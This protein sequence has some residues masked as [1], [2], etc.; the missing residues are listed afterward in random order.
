VGGVISPLLA[1]IYLNP[2][3]H[4]M[5]QQGFEMVRYAD[6]FVILCQTPEEAEHALRLVKEWTGSAGLALHP[7]KTSI[8]NVNE[9]GFEFLGYRFYKDRRWPRKKSLETFK[10]ALRV[11]TKRTNGCSLEM[12]ITSINPII[13]GWFGYFQHCYKTVFTGL[14]GWIRGRLRAILRRRKRLRGRARGRDHQRWP[15]AFFAEKGL[16][17][18]AAA[19]SKACQSARR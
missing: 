15:N 3:D 1:N 11:K 16:F 2:L 8:V 19:Y 5:A 12:I 6:D 14:D 13:R 4:L 9:T 17:S 18:M 7:E 10:N